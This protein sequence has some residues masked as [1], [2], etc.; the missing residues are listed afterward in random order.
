MP[1]KARSALDERKAFIREWSKQE[2]PLAAL[3]R[4][5]RISRQTGYKWL[6]RYEAEGARGLEERSRAPHHSPQQMSE[7]VREAIVAL[8]QSY[9]RWGPRKLR[10]VLQR[11][12]PDQ[13]WPAVSSMGALL[14]REGLA[15]PR[16]KRRRTPP[17]TA[18]LE[19]AQA[20][21]Q[22]W[23]GDYK[24]WF[25]CGDGARCDPLT[26]TDA[27]SRYLLRCQQVERTDQALAR[28]VFEAAFREY[29][30]PE[31]IRTD[32]GPPFA[33]PAPGG[34]S[35]LSIWWMRLGIRHERIQP[36][37]PEQNG[38]HERMHQTLKQETA[39]PPQA[40]LRKQQEAFHRF[41]QQY[42][43][44]RPHEAL[45]YRTPA[46]HYVA[47]QR[48]YPEKL[49]EIEYPQGMRLRR[50]SERGQLALKRHQEIC[51]SKALAHETV[52]LWKIEENLYEV[53]F[54]SLLLGWLDSREL[55][56][57]ADRA[58]VWHAGGPEFEDESQEEFG[59]RLS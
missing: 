34:L 31:A 33:T 15:H 54:G 47:S 25:R 32:N 56:F 38:R 23:C 55:G 51:V 9:S 40:N 35:R 45:G 12:Q 24:G 10:A 19:H 39:S 8:R 13:R 36:G 48:L 4:D 1:W 26:I 44:V 49:P 50:I 2:V 57:V 42:N 21:N 52:G 46:S 18:P 28:A 29:G 37:C 30:M 41:Q 53:Y 6:E 20:P 43:Q 58:P 22:V 17:C 5:Y 3:C 27:F 14:R 59:N 11:Q 7:K 16:R